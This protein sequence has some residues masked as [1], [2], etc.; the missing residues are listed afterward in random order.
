VLIEEKRGG[1][2]DKGYGHVE[3]MEN[4]RATNGTRVYHI[5]TWDDGRSVENPNGE[6]LP[7]FALGNTGTRL[8][9]YKTKREI[10]GESGGT[11]EHDRR[12]RA[13]V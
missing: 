4:S 11:V 5:P 8:Y 1:T 10:T 12:P 6:G 9:V 2:G 7:P 3:M 13:V